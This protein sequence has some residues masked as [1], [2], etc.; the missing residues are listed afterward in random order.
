LNGSLRKKLIISKARVKMEINDKGYVNYVKC[1]HCGKLHTN[2]KII[3]KTTVASLGNILGI[4]V[5]NDSLIVRKESGKTTERIRRSV[6]RAW[7][8][9]SAKFFTYK[10]TACEIEAK[11]RGEH[12]FYLCREKLHDHFK[13]EHLDKLEKKHANERLRQQ[14]LLTEKDPLFA[15]NEIAARFD[16]YMEA[17]NKRNEEY[18]REVNNLHLSPPGIGQN[19]IQTTICEVDGVWFVSE[20][21][22]DS[23]LKIKGLWEPYED[24]DEEDDEEEYDEHY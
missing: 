15:G 24:E 3:K 8:W 18:T 4:P 13:E 5:C 14:A 11:L 16:Y 22:T 23:G 10:A 1:P 6:R 2:A 7:V 9:N 19:R 20:T 12:P 21:Y 17:Q